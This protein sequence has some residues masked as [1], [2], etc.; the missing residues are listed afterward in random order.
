MTNKPLVSVLLAV[1][2]GRPEFLKAVE[3]VLT[4]THS[5]FELL[6]GFNGC[7][8]GCEQDMEKIRLD[9]GPRTNHIREFYYPDAGKSITLNKMLSE[10]KAHWIAIQDHDDYWT[11]GKLDLQMRALSHADHA[12]TDV[13]GTWYRCLGNGSDFDMNHPLSHSSIRQFMYSGKNA[14]GN[15][16]A[17]VRRSALEAM[18]G[19]RSKWDGV[20]DYDLWL[21][22]LNAGYKF[23]N[24]PYQTVTHTLRPNS[25]FNT[26][27]HDIEKLLEENRPPEE[28]MGNQ[29]SKAVS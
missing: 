12:R 7:T 20:E 24:L 6:I 1:H 10:A 17:I 4:Q 16:T 27:K 29:E 22:M 13:L 2:N 8:D 18:K 3:S 9:F 11:P 21:R 14:I 23:G 26:K 28:F 15:T 19:W 25:H 5:D